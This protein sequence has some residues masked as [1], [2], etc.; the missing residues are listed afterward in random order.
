MNLRGNVYHGKDWKKKGEGWNYLIIIF[1]NIFMFLK[2][3]V[4]GCCPG[5]RKQTFHI[6]LP[7]TFKSPLEARQ[8]LRHILSFILASINPVTLEGKTR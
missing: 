7:I 4:G 8:K 1:K 6:I 2:K 5:I 3:N